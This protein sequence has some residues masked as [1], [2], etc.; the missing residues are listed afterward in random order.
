M[1]GF[2]RFETVEELAAAGPFVV[3]SARPAGKDGPPSFAIKIYRTNDILSDPEVVD[4][5]A[6]AF[7]EAAKLQHSLPVGGVS[8]GEGHWAGIYE[9]GRTEEAAYYVTD[10]YPTTA[11]RIVDSR[12]ELNAAELAWIIGGVVDGLAELAKQAHGRGHGGLTPSNVLI[13]RREEIEGANVALTD[14]EPDSRLDPKS[15]TQD[16]RDV[17]GLLFQLVIYRPPPKGGEVRTGPE[18]QRLGE[19]GEQFRLLCEQLINPHPGSPLLT[20]EQ[21]K[22]RL[23]ASL[24]AK[25]KPAVVAEKGKGT[26]WIAV[27]AVALL[28]LGVGAYFALAHKSGPPEDPIP[29]GWYMEEVKAVRAKLTS[30]TKK[31]DDNADEEHEKEAARLDKELAAAEK[32]VS[33]VQHHA[34]PQTDADVRVLLTNQAQAKA[35]HASVEKKIDALDAAIIVLKEED[36]PRGRDAQR[37]MADKLAD[38]N[39]LL[40]QVVNDTP[41]EGGGGPDISALRQ[42]VQGLVAKVEHTRG[43]PWPTEGADLKQVQAEIRTSV[44]E[45]LAEHRSL[46][47]SLSKADHEAGAAVAGYLQKQK[48]LNLSGQIVASDALQEAFAAGLGIISDALNDRDQKLG[49]QGVRARVA[50][51]TAWLK[52]LEDDLPA[53]LNVQVPPGSG[54]ELKPAQD[55]LQKE[56]EQRFKAAVS[57]RA[58]PAKGDAAYA[59]DWARLKESYLSLVSS[60]KQVLG[61]AAE[62][63][64][65]MA[66]AYGYDDAGP[67][68]K[69]IASLRAAIEGAAAYP[70]IK[71]SV[72]GVLQRAAQLEQV[73]AMSDSGG[74]TRLIKSSGQTSTSGAWSGTGVL[75]AAWKRLPKLGYPATPADLKE[76]SELFAGSVAP[77]LAAVS[78]ST[79]RVE[80]QNQAGAVAKDMWFN[81]VHEVAGASGQPDL[82]DAAFT[83]RSNFG[84]TDADM[85]ARLE[86]WAKY[87]LERW[88]L[89]GA[90]LPVKAQDRK[91]QI[92]S[93]QDL[94]VPFELRAAAIKDLGQRSAVEDLTAR[95][96]HFAEGKDLDLTAEGPA[97]GKAWQAQPKADG[98]VVTYT[99]KSRGGFDHTLEFRR[100]DETADAASYLCTTEV[101]LRLCIDVVDSLGK[102]EDVRA[103]T[104][105]GHADPNNDGRRGPRVTAWTGRDGK[106]VLSAPS[107]PDKTGLGWHRW[108]PPDNMKDIPYY[109]DGGQP[110]PVP[111]PDGPPKSSPVLDDPVDF[112]APG[113]AVY[114]ARLLNCRLP[115][116]TEWQKANDDYPTPKP[117]LRDKTWARQWDYI[118]SLKDQHKDNGN[119]DWPN[120]SMLRKKGATVPPEVD[121]QPAVDADDGMLYFL[122]VNVGGDSVTK[123]GGPVFHHLVGNV[124]EFVFE[125]ADAMNK[126]AFPPTAQNIKEILG[127]GDKLRAIGGS[128]ISPKDYDPKEPLKFTFTDK[129]D[130]FSDA[131]FRLAFSTGGGGGGT[132]NP[133]DQLANI[134]SSTPYLTRAAK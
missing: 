75:S 113:A 79:R 36:D 55:A 63:E 53:S 99:W 33:G 39:K 41:T 4:R 28:A 13:G 80:L 1:P 18:W 23:A 88:R 51:L 103:F 96:K 76:A 40:D 5:E 43:R 6:A 92:K 45:A 134:L 46:T 82:V 122:P 17:G 54:V 73:A 69:S 105:M 58:M 64:S 50:D 77:A 87:N 9:M 126:A 59:A 91:A 106:M 38:L 123:D 109:P 24:A 95:L 57:G 93:L 98:K 37:W 130:G 132:G 20:L 68:G 52:G 128:A 81:F 102:W 85:T 30:A 112:I 67:G 129:S 60:V 118:K 47:D 19:A 61:D 90:V 11:Q 125:D 101:S 32:E 127:K 14:P 29:P 111:V 16:L 97:R 71:A 27:A 115:T 3:F 121:G 2:G 15:Q 26:K 25:A 8:A 131:G 21:I 110:A 56:R 133:A 42:G 104:D 84:I 100:I 94:V 116:P 124:C 107:N 22:E 12:R 48:D 44:K 117:N 31:A 7:L 35:D 10:L 72:D 49:W 86:P 83:A 119:A 34:P 114:V 70:Q 89:L 78:D 65:L 66:L 108:V 120:Q 62:A 74:L